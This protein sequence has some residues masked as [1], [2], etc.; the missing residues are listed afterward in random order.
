MNISRK[1]KNKP[2]PPFAAAFKEKKMDENIERLRKIIGELNWF[3]DEYKDELKKHPE[4][5]EAI[6]TARNTAG[7][8][9]SYEK[10][11]KDLDG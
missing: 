2:R 11:W 4:R 8:F 10:F 6:R 7:G 5:A 9:L 1:K 3:Y